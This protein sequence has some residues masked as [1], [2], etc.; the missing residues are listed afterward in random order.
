M[1]CVWHSGRVERCQTG[2]QPDCQHHYELLEW[3]RNTPGLHQ[4]SAPDYHRCQLEHFVWAKLQADIA[5]QPRVLD[6]G[7]YERRAWVGPNYRT[8]GPDDTDA[9]YHGDITALLPDAPWDAIICTEV[10]EHCADPVAAVRRIYAALRPGGRLL[11]SSPFLW[12]DHRT[13]NYPDYWRIT[14]QGWRSL[15]RDFATVTVE[16]SRWTAG[17]AAAYHLLRDCEGM[18]FSGLTRATTGYN[19][20][21]IK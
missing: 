6:I 13:E 19:V 10:L 2:E 3:R 14:E 21:A 17:G 11:A 16:E 1:Q 20:E 8:I 15:L 5:S 4:F 9:D 12:P 18:G 7:V